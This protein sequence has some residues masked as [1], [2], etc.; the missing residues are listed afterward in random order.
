MQNGKIFISYR[1][2]D[3]SGEAGRLNENLEQI[4][5]DENVYFDIEAIGGGINFKK[6]IERALNSCKVLIAVIGPR[7]LN[8]TDKEGERRL[9]NPDDF[10]RL[11]ISTALKR[12]IMV[13]PLLINGASQP[14]RDEL[15]EDIENLAGLNSMDLSN[16]RWRYDFNELVK[17]L[18]KKLRKEVVWVEYKKWFA[19]HYL[20]VA[21]FFLMLFGASL[22]A[23]FYPSFYDELFSN[24]PT[25]SAQLY[26]SNSTSNSS[27]T[28]NGAWN[29]FRNEALIGGF[30][31]TVEGDQM[32]FIHMYFTKVVGSGDG[33]IRGDKVSLSY[34]NSNSKTLGDIEL[35]TSDGGMSW[36]GNINIP[37]NDIDGPVE[38]RRF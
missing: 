38:L 34:F 22:L 21:A 1:R 19:K 32:T 35:T 26:S 7:W 36:K 30:I 4:F 28:I 5:G 8:I 11:E 29:A 13:I 27:N 14:K 20:W 24:Q 6:D 37:N 2:E 16:K 18:K 33:K 15:P 12:G 31:F 3:S 17:I 23:T 9:E 25:T 10:I